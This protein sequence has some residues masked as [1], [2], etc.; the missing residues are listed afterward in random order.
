[1]G[2]EWRQIGLNSLSQFLPGVAGT[3]REKKRMLG[4][5]I[6]ADPREA[7]DQAWK[8]TEVEREAFQVHSI[9]SDWN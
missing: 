8:R 1:M 3:T 9:T 6:E 4:E 5:G 7:T 2:R